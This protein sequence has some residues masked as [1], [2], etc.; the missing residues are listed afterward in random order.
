MDPAILSEAT[1]GS[2]GTFAATLRRRRAR[3]RAHPGTLSFLPRLDAVG[4]HL[5][6]VQA[7]LQAIDPLPRLAS[8]R[9]IGRA[10]GARGRRTAASLQQIRDRDVL[11]LA[12]R[13]AASWPEAVRL[14][15]ALS[16]HA[17]PHSDF[18]SELRD[19]LQETGLPP[20]R[21]DL[22]FAE[23]GLAADD[24]ALH[25]MLAAMRDCGIGIF[26]SG[27]GGGTSSLTLLRDLADAGLISGVQLDA[28]VLCTSP[29]QWRDK[30]LLG[31]DAPSAAFF[32][33]E[34]AAI[35]ALGLR[36]RLVGVDRPQAL[37]F[38]GS[39]GFDEVSGML[40]APMQSETDFLAEVNGDADA[41]K[42]P[43]R[44]KSRRPA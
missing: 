29:V 17:A 26:W 33:A 2:H 12:C 44:R 6:G 37:A 5:I 8:T 18:A 9:A 22:A 14:M 23:D 34:I 35:R 32:A 27:F 40:V 28:G 7:D 13:A 16:D 24:P 4:G 25:P 41:G 3:S 31:E 1:A 19:M 20:A 21:L 15:I 10:T 36:I 43:A 42:G 39:T 11:R 38:A 30:A